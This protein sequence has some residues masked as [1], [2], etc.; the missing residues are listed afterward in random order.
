MLDCSLL[1]DSCDYAVEH[2]VND[3]ENQ[4]INGEQH[5]YWNRY[6]NNGQLCSEGYY[7]NGERDGVFL[8]FYRTGGLMYEV[9]YV[10][11]KVH[12]ESCHYYA[13]GGLLSKSI[14]EDGVRKW[15]KWFK[16]GLE[17]F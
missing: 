2:L 9:S 11:G 4:Y 13:R 17:D 15:V 7:V 6:Y 10:N 3:R 14:F 8:T 1:P 5:G 16:E 12:G